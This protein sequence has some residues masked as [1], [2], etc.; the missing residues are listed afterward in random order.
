MRYMLDTNMVS[1]LIREKPPVVLRVVGLPMTSLCISTI[2]E[3]E[4]VF[5]LAKRPHATR[6]HRG[7]LEFLRRVE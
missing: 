3:G 1:H 2:T 7:V 5:G 6:L 4:L